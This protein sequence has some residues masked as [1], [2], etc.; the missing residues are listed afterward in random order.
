MMGKREASLVE[1]IYYDEDLI[2]PEKADIKVETLKMQKKVIKASLLEKMSQ[3]NMKY[4]ILSLS[5]I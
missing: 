3:L 5:E 1:R 2:A 4:N